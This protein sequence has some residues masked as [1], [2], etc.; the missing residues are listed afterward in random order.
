MKNLLTFIAGLLFGLGLIVS[1]M[2]NP[3]K[4]IG[5]L[6]LFGRWDPSLM[7][8]MLGAIPVAFF[9]F[10]FIEKKRTTIFNEP[11]HL[12]GKTHLNKALVVGSLIFGAGWALAGF[13]PGPA[14]VSLGSGNTSALIF[15]VAMSAGMAF[16]DHLY[17]PIFNPKST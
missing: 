15:V 3:Y 6:D 16:H 14:L 8:V 17:K 9:G 2:T 12:S 13:C 10:N 7:F 11:L 1:G 5:F 4:V